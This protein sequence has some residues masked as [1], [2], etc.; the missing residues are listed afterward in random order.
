MSSIILLILNEDA[1]LMSKASL[2]LFSVNMS[3]QTSNNLHSVSQSFV[4]TANT[5]TNQSA[6]KPTKPGRIKKR[7]AH[8][9]NFLGGLVCTRN[10]SF[11]LQ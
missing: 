4:Y 3:C 2:I 11:R 10:L 5:S 9:E 7:A 6:S 8:S 1:M